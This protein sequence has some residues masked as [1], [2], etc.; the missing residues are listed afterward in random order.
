MNS[1]YPTTSTYQSHQTSFTSTSSSST[2][3]QPNI[4]PNSSID[5]TASHRQQMQVPSFLNNQK[6]PAN[7]GTKIG[8]SGQTV[9]MNAPVKTTNPVPYTTQ[10]GI[11]QNPTIWRKN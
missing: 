8:Y 3:Q 10:P 5:S 7:Q 2:T 4:N 1:N 11:V 9:P 6:M